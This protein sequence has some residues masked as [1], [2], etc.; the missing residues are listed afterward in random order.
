VKEYEVGWKAGF[1]NGHLR[2]QLDAYY[3]TTTIPSHRRIPELS[4]VWLRAQR[5][6]TTTMYGAEAQAE[7][8]FGAFSL[9]AAWACC[10]ARSANFSLSI[11]GAAAVL[12]RCS[13]S[14]T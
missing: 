3:T 6:N 11:H 13:R 7:A 4:D 8:V 1:F 10:T 9:D 5:S 12:S 2:T 14:A